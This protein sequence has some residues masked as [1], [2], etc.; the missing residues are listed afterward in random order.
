MIFRTRADFCGLEIEIWR[1]SNEEACVI[2]GR[3]ADF[4]G[5]DIEFSQKTVYKFG[6]I[7]IIWFYS[8]FKI[9]IP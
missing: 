8:V 5:L 1:F 9:T 2:F 6:E 7:L 3:H 4:C